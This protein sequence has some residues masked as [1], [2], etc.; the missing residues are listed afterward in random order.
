MKTRLEAGEVDPTEAL[1]YLWEIADPGTR[2]VIYRY[3]GKAKNGG[4]RPLS[5]YKRNVRNLL[6]DRPYRKGRPEGFRAVHQRLTEAVRSGQEITLRFFCNVRPDESIN[7]FE[8]AYRRRY[9][10]G[11]NAGREIT[12]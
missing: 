3:V 1:I 12:R 6:Q 2:T 7:E 8:R 9:E 5:D 11:P 4:G 10:L